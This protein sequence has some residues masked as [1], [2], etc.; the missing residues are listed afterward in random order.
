MHAAFIVDHRHLVIAHRARTRRVIRR[1]GARTHEGV[2]FRV[3]LQFRAG[4]Q[5]AATETIE[6]RLADDLARNADSVAELAPVERFGHVVEENRRMLTRITRAQLDVPPARRA[7]GADVRLEAV[8]LDCV[9]A[10][11][12]D[13]HRQEVILDVRPRIVIAG[14]D[15]A[16]SLEVVARAD[17]GALEHPFQPDGRLIAQQQRRIERDGFLALVL[18]VHLEVVLQILTHAR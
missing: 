1:F 11:V 6:R 17:A 10:V 7:H 9:G 4:A 5:L 14:A 15:K 3:A 8:H 18:H 13:R 16:A 12:V 2:D